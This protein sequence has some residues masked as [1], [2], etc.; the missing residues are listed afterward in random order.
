MRVIAKIGLAVCRSRYRPLTKLTC[1][2]PSRGIRASSSNPLPRPAPSCIVGFPRASA[3]AGH[4]WPAPSAAEAT[5]KSAALWVSH[6]RAMQLAVVLFGQHELESDI[7]GSR[8]YAP[9]SGAATHTGRAQSRRLVMG[10]TSRTWPARHE[11][12][13]LYCRNVYEHVL[14]AALRLDDVVRASVHH[15]AEK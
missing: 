6:R 15:D 2:G 9:H 8:S 12:A 1:P 5:I 11:A 13:A 14:A 7:H 4:D 10:V 3:A